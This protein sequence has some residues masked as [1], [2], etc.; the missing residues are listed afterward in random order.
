MLAVAGAQRP[1]D[2]SDNISLGADVGRGDKALRTG[3]AQLL[4]NQ[5][6]IHLIKGTHQLIQQQ[7][8]GGLYRFQGCQ[9]QQ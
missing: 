3:D 1:D 6:R 9:H 7:D 4:Q 5:G 2:V 8:G